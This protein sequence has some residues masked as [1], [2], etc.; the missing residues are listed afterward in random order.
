M[1]D[2]FARTCIGN[3]ILCLIFGKINCYNLPTSVGRIRSIS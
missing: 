1:L 2:A 3:E